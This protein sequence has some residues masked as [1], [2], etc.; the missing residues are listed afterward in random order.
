MYVLA[1]NDDAG[2]TI[3]FSSILFETDE[4]A[5]RVAKEKYS[6]WLKEYHLFPFKLLPYI[7]QNDYTKCQ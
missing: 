3:L 6:Y 4:Q 2:A 7:D 5:I 1:Y